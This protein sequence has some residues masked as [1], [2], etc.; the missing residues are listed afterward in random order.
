MNNYEEFLLNNYDKAIKLSNRFKKTRLLVWTP[1]D[2]LNE[3]AIQI[4]HVFNIDNKDYSEEGRNINNLGD[5]L[6]DVLLQ[7]I[8]LSQL[9]N[10]NLKEYNS[11]DVVNSY[12]I[13]D[14]VVLFGQVTEAIMEIKKQ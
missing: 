12:N 7:L 8:A 9:L 2:V 3:L 4:G 10:I 1:L 6:S 14:I 11:S 5:E 13:N